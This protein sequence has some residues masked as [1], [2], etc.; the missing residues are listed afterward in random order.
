VGLAA[1]RMALEGRLPVRD[2]SIRPPGPP[3][4]W[5]RSLQYGPRYHQ[6]PQTSA[7]IPHPSADPAATL[8]P[9]PAHAA[10]VSA[11]HSHSL[12]WCRP[13]TT[14]SRTVVHSAR[15]TTAPDRHITWSGAVS[16][17]WR[18]MDSNQHPARDWTR[19]GKTVDART[20]SRPHT[21]RC[22]IAVNACSHTGTQD[23]S[24]G[25]RRGGGPF[26]SLFWDTAVVTATV[27]TTPMAGDSATVGRF[28]V[29]GVRSA[30]GDP[31]IAYGGPDPPRRARGARVIGRLPST[32]C[33]SVSATS[34]WS[35]TPA[36]GEATSSWSGAA[37]RGRAWGG[38][39]V[40]R[41]L[42]RWLWDRPRHRAPRRTRRVRTSA[43]GRGLGGSPVAARLVVTDP[44]L[45]AE[46]GA[47]GSL[48]R[49]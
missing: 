1:W 39:L 25:L 7:Q 38:G 45:G 3:A 14:V 43:M 13:A 15:A 30:G 29:R 32:A 16:A 46:P 26:A 40:P 48:L 47:V 35:C 36:R 10:D 17:A 42:A 9:P 18:V 34:L 4:R 20:S 28:P 8:L 27:S 22:R 11:G 2:S 24:D 31:S 37:A 21:R 41:P 19:P 23:N 44:F 5:R 12:R 33:K 6:D 49:A